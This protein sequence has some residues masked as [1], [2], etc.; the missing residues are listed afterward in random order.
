MAYKHFRSWC[1][2]FRALTSYTKLSRTNQLSGLVNTSTCG[3]TPAEVKPKQKYTCGN[4]EISLQ[5]GPK[6]RHPVNRKHSSCAQFH[7]LL[8]LIGINKVSLCQQCFH[9]YLSTSRCHSCWVLLQIFVKFTFKRKQTQSP[10]IQLL[11]RQ[12]KRDKTQVYSCPRIFQMPRLGRRFWFVVWRKIW[13]CHCCAIFHV[14]DSFDGD[15]CV[16]ALYKTRKRSRLTGV[17]MNVVKL[18]NVL[19]RDQPNINFK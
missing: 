19:W 6:R 18:I 10:K 3:S 16:V 5:C 14:L 2:S 12:W 9:L 8:A 17:D 1:C 13:T 15:S 7:L 11:T 4:S